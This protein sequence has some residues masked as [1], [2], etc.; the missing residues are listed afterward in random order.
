VG[1][2]S[3]DKGL[4]SLCCHEWDESYD[5]Y[6]LSVCSAYMVVG[7]RHEARVGEVEQNYKDEASKFPHLLIV[8]SV[9]H[10]TQGS[11]SKQEEL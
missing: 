3:S 6:F 9:L 4:Y 2:S 1:V 7:A 10:V 8:H 11:V 5:G